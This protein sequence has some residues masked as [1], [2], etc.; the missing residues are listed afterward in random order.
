[1]N[2][3]LDIHVTGESANFDVSIG[4]GRDEVTSV[5]ISRTLI[6]PQKQAELESSVREAV[7]AALARYTAKL[8]EVL[9]QLPAVPPPTE[10][11]ER[12]QASLDE[13]LRRGGLT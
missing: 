5:R 9:R 3:P 6:D 11:I 8:G 13:L 10:E 4:F 1:M 12:L 2:D 7:N